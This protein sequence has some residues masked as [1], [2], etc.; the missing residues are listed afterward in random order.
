MPK[1][2]KKSD[3]LEAVEVPEKR[4]S[5]LNK[6]YNVRSKYRDPYEGKLIWSRDGYL[7]FEDEQGNFVTERED[8][9]RLTPIIK[10][11]AEEV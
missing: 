9:C 3:K 11:T 2:K 10:I 7:G 8:T 4:D 5:R 6:R 1:Q